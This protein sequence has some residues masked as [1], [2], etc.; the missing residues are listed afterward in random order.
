MRSAWL[1]IPLADY[2]GHMAAPGVGQAEMLATQFAEFLGAWSPESVAVIGCAGGNG[3]DRLHA[4]VTRRVVGIDINPHYIQGLAER[5]GDRIPGLELYVHDIQ[6]PVEQI[7]PVDF[8]YAALVFEYVAP[9]P[10]LQNLKSLCRPGAALV[11]VLQLPSDQGGT[12]SESPFISLKGLASAMHLVSPTSLAADA[13]EIGFSRLS[14]RRV[15]LSSGKEF[16]VQA[17]LLKA[18]GVAAP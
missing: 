1:D 10:V 13:T 9:Q 12:V 17:F 7:P 15:R 18:D 6:Q 14:S 2:E 11:T 4:E 16:A 5:Y 8:I 3:F